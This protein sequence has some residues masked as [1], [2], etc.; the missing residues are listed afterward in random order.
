MKKHI[1]NFITLLNLASGTLGIYMIFQGNPS[2]A[3]IF[4]F[5]AIVFDFLDGLAARVLNSASE[6]GKQLD[7]LAD[8]VSF[9]LLSAAM[10]Y[11]ILSKSFLSDASDLPGFSLIEIV[12]LGSVVLVP[13]MAA[14]RLAKFNLQKDTSY[15]LGL[16]VPA[17]ALFWAGIFYDIHMNELFLGKE[18]NSWF[19]WAVMLLTSALMVIP[20]PM[21]SFKFSNFK[22]RENSGRYM[23]LLIAVLI[24]AFSGIPGLPIVIL[25]Y[26][27]LSLV[28]ILLT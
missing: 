18:L 21:I 16:P 20:L 28:N 22:F 1:P 8:I 15:F 26:I 3:L 12:L 24:L 14:I 19:I 9:G 10:I 27:L 23:L 13:M 11:S 17:F 6:I 2:W 7:S 25:M 5:A 4:F